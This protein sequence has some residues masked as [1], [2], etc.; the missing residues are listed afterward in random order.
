MAI[1]RFWR[2]AFTS[3]VIA[4]AA[5]AE[6]SAIDVAHGIYSISIARDNPNAIQDQRLDAIRDYDF[7]SGYTLRVFWADIEPAEGVYDFT[8]IDE[9]LASR[10]WD[11]G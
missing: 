1:P 8:V 4:L 10:R 9:A 5:T 7:V 2:H 3:T 11:R 6:A